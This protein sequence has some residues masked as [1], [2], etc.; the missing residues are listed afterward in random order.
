MVPQNIHSS[1]VTILVKSLVTL[2]HMPPIVPISKLLAFWS[3][4]GPFSSVFCYSTDNWQRFQSFLSNCDW[5]LVILLWFGNAF[6]THSKIYD[7]GSRNIHCHNPDPPILAW[8]SW[9]YVKL[10]KVVHFQ[11]QRKAF[12][13]SSCSY[14]CFRFLK[15]V[16]MP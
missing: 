10:L 14:L 9:P 3:N 8:R 15:L 12:L 6:E 13:F 5:P 1:A 4:F 2:N 16:L 7:F 11:M